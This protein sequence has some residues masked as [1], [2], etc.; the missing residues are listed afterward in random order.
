MVPRRFARA[1]DGAPENQLKWLAD[2]N[3]DNNILR[4]I[5]RRAAGFDVIRTQDGAEIPGLD[6]AAVLAWATA[7]DRVVLTHDLST[8]IPAMREQV[9]RFISCAPIVM[10]R[11]SLPVS[12][13]IGEVLL[14]NE[15]AI[16]NDWAAAVIFR[17]IDE[18]R[19]TV[20]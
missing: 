3:F 14:L 12:L 2:E 16:E 5:W 20:D 17:S 11:D 10:V 13:V 9:R 15:C 8:M 7:N 18:R 19:E 6:D 1:F 4:G